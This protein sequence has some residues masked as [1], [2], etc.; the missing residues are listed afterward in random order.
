MALSR[1]VWPAIITLPEDPLPVVG[2]TYSYDS[3]SLPYDFAVGA[4]YDTG[5]HPNMGLY[6]RS[7]QSLTAKTC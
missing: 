7:E 1:D 4:A 6:S 3:S 2:Q 5:K